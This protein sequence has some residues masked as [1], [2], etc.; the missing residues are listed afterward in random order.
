M[1]RVVQHAQAVRAREFSN[2]IVIAEYAIVV[3]HDDCFRAWRNEFRGFVEVDAERIFFDV[4]ENGLGAGCEN[5]LEVGGVV[6]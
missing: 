3:H 4:A 5:G 2:A 1:G 6:E